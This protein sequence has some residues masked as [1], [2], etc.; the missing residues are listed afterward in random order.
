MQ[1]LLNPIINFHSIR[2]LRASRIS[3][4][5]TAAEIQQCPLNCPVLT[6]FIVPSFF[7]IT[8][9]RQKQLI[10]MDYQMKISNI[11]CKFYNFGE[12]ACPFG[13][14]CYYVSPSRELFPYNTF[15]PEIVAYD[16]TADRRCRRGRIFHYTW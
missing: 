4:G 15:L 6:P 9:A 14:E 13:K 7:W 10:F 11:P 3:A 5:M 12:N 16:S 1:Y 8:N 2:S